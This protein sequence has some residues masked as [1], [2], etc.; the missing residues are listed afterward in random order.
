MLLHSKI[1]APHTA[2]AYLHQKQIQSFM[3]H[4]VSNI[5]R[6]CFLQKITIKEKEED[7]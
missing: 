3:V 2:A 5:K 7:N 6:N 4:T 1:S